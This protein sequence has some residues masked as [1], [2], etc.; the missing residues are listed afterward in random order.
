MMEIRRRLGRPV[1]APVR[2]VERVANQPHARPSFPA[3]PPIRAWAAELI[4]RG[5]VLSPTGCHPA[6]PPPRVVLPGRLTPIAITCRSGEAS[7]DAA[8]PPAIEAPV[9]DHATPESWT[10]ALHTHTRDRLP[11]PSER[12]CSASPAGHR[13]PEHRHPE[14][15]GRRGR[16]HARIA[17]RRP[18]ELI[19]PGPGPGPGRAGRGEGSVAGPQ[20]PS[21]IRRKTY[22]VS[23][24]GQV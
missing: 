23:G 10:G 22:T 24:P 12:R 6:V 14:R 3:L 9:P 19:P 15:R 18:T 4:C 5:R 21:T 16:T 13:Y 1:V 7:P 20:A 2:P 8:R 11:V 17:A